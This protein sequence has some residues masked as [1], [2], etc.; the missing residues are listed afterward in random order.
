MAGIVSSPRRQE[1]AAQG[2]PRRVHQEFGATEFKECSDLRLLRDLQGVVDFDAQVADR[3]FK[4][5][6]AKQQ[7]HRPQVLEGRTIR[8]QVLAQPPVAW[9]LSGS[10][11]SV[12]ATRWR[13]APS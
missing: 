1:A 12:M 10:A 8:L 4:L 2:R 9:W 6:V 5:G 11:T 13:P 3:R 7:L